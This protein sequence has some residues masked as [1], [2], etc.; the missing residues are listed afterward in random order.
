MIL[1]PV[2]TSGSEGLP[3]HQHTLLLYSSDDDKV[4]T[5]YVS[6]G[7]DRGHLVI[8]IP[9]NSDIND[10]TSY[11]SKMEMASEIVNYEDYVNGGN[12][13]TLNIRPFYNSALARNT[14]PFEELKI[15][16]EE[17]IK[18]RI[19]S[20]KNDEVTFVSSIGGTLAT[21]QKFDESIDS[22]KW[23][24][25]TYSEWLKKGLKVTMVCSHPKKLFDKSHQFMDYKQA[26][27]SLHNITLDSMSR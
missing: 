23:W 6:E 14:E 12:L 24:H 2:N 25:K 17:A 19:T 20:G 11:M 22:E 26:M 1:D 18:E 15:L 21:N 7:L 3:L 9:I 16:L 4:H 13:L 10:N 8:Y 27:S 5:K